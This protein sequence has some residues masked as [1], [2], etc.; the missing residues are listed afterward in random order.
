MIKKQE[1]PI[2]EFD[3]SAQAVITPGHMVK[4]TEVPE[5]CVLCFF[6]DV[7]NKIRQK[8]FMRHIKNL[9]S[10][11]GPHPVMV[12]EYEGQEVTI[13]HPGVGAALSAALFEEM[14]EIGC[15]KFIACGSAGVLDRDI[16]VG[17]LLV[18]TTAVR[19]EGTSYHYL[20]A[21]REVEA[22]RNALQAIESVLQEKQ[23]DYLLTKTW[24]T[25]AIY[26]ETPEKVKLRKSEGCLAVEMEAAALFAVARF[27][28]VSIGH[29]L[30]SGDSVATDAWESRGWMNQPTIRENL[31]WLAVEACLRIA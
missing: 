10:E 8:P 20:P 27:R 5:T 2:L 26:R 11:I 4:K 28:D 1:F 7:M 13:F 23:V 6:R 12:A 22:S 16:A 31:F 3:P 17:H 15:R 24:T 21:A 14:I 29:I 25:D 19:D 18:P 30:Y 9:Q